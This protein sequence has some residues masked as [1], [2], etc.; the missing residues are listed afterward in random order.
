MPL[1]AYICFCFVASATILV[2]PPDARAC[3]WRCYHPGRCQTQPYCP[4]GQVIAAGAIL[5]VKVA[6]NAKLY[7]DDQLVEGSGETRVFSTAPIP[8]G[9]DQTFTLRSVVSNDPVK[10]SSITG[11]AGDA[12]APPVDPKDKG[13]VPPPKPESPSAKE[14]SKKVT[15]RANQVATVDL[16]GN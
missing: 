14:L 9:R 16:T 12:D 4:D 2:T 7:L 1:R 6:P 13:P 10:T 5:I 15:L 8:L 11:L 3:W